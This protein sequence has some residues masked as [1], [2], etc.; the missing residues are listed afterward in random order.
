MNLHVSLS[1]LLMWGCCMAAEASAVAATLVDAGSG[2]PVNAAAQQCAAEPIKTTGTV[3]YV[4]D[5][6]P[7]ADPNCAPGDD[8]KARTSRSSPWRTYQKARSTF[9]R[10]G[11][12]DTIA[13]CRGGRFDA[14]AGGSWVNQRCRAGNP[15]VVRDYSP[16]WGTGT[17]A[18]PKLVS[19]GQNLLDLA[20]PGNANHEEGYR[21]LNLEL[22]GSGS[23]WGVFAYNDVD[24]VTLCNMVIDGFDI[25]VHVAGSN[26]PN[27]GSDG[28]NE[29]I[30]LR[31][32]RIVNNASMGFLGACDGCVVESNSFDNNG[33]P[34]TI[35]HHSIYL[36]GMR[37][38]NGATYPVTGMRASNNELRHS[39]HSNG[40]CV[41]TALVAHGQHQELVIENNLIVE[42]VGTAD[43]GCWGIGVVTGRYPDPEFFRNVV[44]RGN[45]VVNVG[46]VAIGVS[47]C[48][49]CTI[50]NNVVVQGQPFSG[51]AIVAPATDRR[52]VDDMLNAVTI[53]NNTVYYPSGI[54]GTAITLGAEGSGHIVASNAVV[55]AG[56]TDGFKCFNLGLAPASYYSDHNLCWFPPGSRGE[57]GAGYSTLAKWQSAS[58]LDPASRN[59]DPKLTNPAAPDYY[60]IPV[61]SSPLVGAGD[62]RQSSAIDLLGKP[63]ASAPDIGAFQH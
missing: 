51:N 11:A 44:I 60:F 55:S 28:R 61:S 57:W 10:I 31:G 38:G 41:G 50:E 46:N 13:F 4:C 6:G 25:G 49:R 54:S 37:D 45:R 33:N 20:N 36:S 12:G 3:Y 53:R 35:F 9:A 22:D 32:S 40:R 18:A 14:S 8:S 48:Q 34:G 42:D 30:T 15:C 21:F 63:R 62:P 47:A 43:H 59:A 17:K 23:G 52:S 26:P 1:L 29:R 16:P 5:C 24:D 58:S 2:S 27:P 7:G 39:V 56:G 19:S